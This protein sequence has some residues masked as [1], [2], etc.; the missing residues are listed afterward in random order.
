MFKIFIMLIVL[1]LPVS[2]SFADS[3]CGCIIR[4]S[5]GNNVRLSWN[6]SP[7]HE[8]VVGYQL[9]IVHYYYIGLEEE[10]IETTDNFYVIENFPRTSRHFE[11]KIR[12]F[13]V[14]DDVRIYAVNWTSSTDKR[15]AVH[16]GE[17]TGWLIYT[18]PDTPSW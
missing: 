10:V 17:Q 13:K 18:I 9:K 5:S 1:M 7:E 8:N 16:N 11:V 3:F 6:H 12:A 2:T 15:Y 14:V 4:P